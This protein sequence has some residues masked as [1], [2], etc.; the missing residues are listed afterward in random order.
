[1][2]NAGDSAVAT[3]INL[4]IARSGAAFTS[5]IL[6]GTV[7]ECDLIVKGSVGGVARGW[8][9]LPSGLFQ[10]DT[11]N[12]LNDASLRAL[13]Q[14]EGP[15]T[16]TCAPPGSGTRMGVDRDEDGVLDGLDNCVEIA[17]A[18]QLDTD[19]DHIGNDCDD[20]DD[21][22]GLPDGVET[23]TGVYVDANHRG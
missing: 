9:R 12:T 18:S 20:D 15:L 22:D 14:T 19:G 23:N 4:L 8:K 11:G 5:L 16:Y 17:N 6:G 3:R 10:D 7:T 2:T 13:A 21:G 1:A